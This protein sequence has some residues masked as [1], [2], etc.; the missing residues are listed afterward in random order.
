MRRRELIT[1]LGGAVTW[2]LAARAQHTAMSVIGWLGSGSPDAFASQV[3]AFRKG[4]NE[5]GFVEGQNVAIEYRWAEGDYDRLPELAAGLV[6][7]PV[8]VIL[9][10]GGI[11]PALAAKT[12]TSTIPIVFLNGGSDPVAAGLVASFNRP[13]GNV[14][15]VN[16]LAGEL[17][18]KQLALLHELVPAAS[19]IAMLV[20]PN[21]RTANPTMRDL[22]TAARSLGLQ[23]RVLTASTERGIDEVFASIG[24]QPVDALLV[25]TEPF[26]SG[27]RDQIAALATRHAIPT[28]S[29]TQA[30][31]AAGGLISYG[32]SATDAYRQ[33]GVYV[34][35]ILKGEKPA[36]LPVMQPTKFDLVINIKTAKALGLQIPDKLLA[37]ADEVIE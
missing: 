32:A 16:F 23:L 12:A 29:S 9:T 35:R 30:F 19:M 14:T 33:A 2:P 5:T 3:A 36:D 13:G 37:L 28:I 10:S 18:T 15:G 34:G 20:N 7:H 24:Q 26:L 25:Q 8:A 6:H 21:L 11:R 22:E 1:F 17:V 27:Q 31:A 4:V